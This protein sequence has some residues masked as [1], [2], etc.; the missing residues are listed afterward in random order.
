[1]QTYHVPLAYVD[2]QKLAALAR[3]ELAARD[4]PALLEC[5]V[6]AE[7]VRACMEVPGQRYRSGVDAESLAATELQAGTRGMLARRQTTR[8]RQQHA[9][10]RKL[11]ARGKIM[12]LTRWRAR[13]VDERTREE[14]E[15]WDALVER[16]R[17]EWPRMRDAPRVIIHLTSLSA[18]IAQRHSIKDLDVRQN[19]QLPRLCDIRLPNVDVVYVTPFALNEDVTHYF[20]KVLEIGGVEEPQKRYK[21][22]L[23]ENTTRL[24]EKMSLAS[25]LLHS[26]KALRKIVNYCRGKYAYIVPSVV[27]P[28]ER[29]LALALNMP[30]LAPPPATAA[31]FGSKSGAKRIFAAAQ[32]NAPPG[33]HDLYDVHAICSGLAKLI[34]AHLDVPRWVFK[35]DDEFG[36]R[37]HAHLDVGELECYQNLLRV[38]DMSPHTWDD[39]HVQAEVQQEL[40]EELA[41]LLPTHVIINARWLWRSWKE[42]AEA[43]ARVG[44]VIEA[45]PLALSSS[46]SVNVLVAPDGTVGIHSA[47]EQIFSTP[48]TFVGAAFPQTAVPYAALREASLAV[49][50][51]AYERGI[52]G[53]LGVDFVSFVDSAGHLRLWAVD[54]NLRLTHTAV[55]FSFFDFLAGGR[56]DPTHG[57]YTMGDHEKLG[58]VADGGPDLQPRAY[59]MNEMMYHPQLPQLH[60][61]AFFNLCRL[62][63]VSFD[64][65]ERTGTVFN[66]MDSFV[67][68]VLGILTVGSSLLDALRKFADCLDFMQKQVGPATSGKPPTMTHEVTFRDVIKAIK[69]IV[70]ANVGDPKPQPPP[71]PPQPP[72]PPKEPREPTPPEPAVPGVSGQAILPL[73]D[74]RYLDRAKGGSPPAAPTGGAP[75]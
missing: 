66:L 48:Y 75:A 64:L 53:H 60:H 39:V 17:V 47:H 14:G 13:R 67:G 42:Y 29:K 59:V 15:R 6:N 68:G 28:E 7:Q 45:S 55:T 54:L 38:H 51:A 22:V 50:R 27:G 1:M 12:V 43:F 20:A 71:P 3:D 40:Q 33:L 21:I 57:R 25:Y 65:Q 31:A 23:P 4:A 34:C 8:M 19:S 36:G 5:L 63:G 16:F 32:V 74:K 46:P 2:G 62:K 11:T 37:G 41:Q 35:L 24:P 56:W 70:D 58:G 18:S 52:V 9:A 49:G 61:S 73:P 30:L 69:Q 72:P 44:G 26:P 10:A